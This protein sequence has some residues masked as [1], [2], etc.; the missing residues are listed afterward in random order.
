VVCTNVAPEGC[1]GPFREDIRDAVYA[2]L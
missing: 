2:A 1:N